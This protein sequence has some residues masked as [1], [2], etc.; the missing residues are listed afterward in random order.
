MTDPEPYAYNSPKRLFDLWKK[1]TGEDLAPHPKP[2]KDG[3]KQ[4]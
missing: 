3:G 1:L 4:K 2:A